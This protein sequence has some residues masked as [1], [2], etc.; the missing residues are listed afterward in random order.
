MLFLYI[1]YGTKIIN[2]NEYIVGFELIH[3]IKYLSKHCITL[4]LRPFK[5]FIK[6]ISNNSLTKDHSQAVYLI[7][8]FN[9]VYFAFII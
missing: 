2:T 4:H 9:S 6:C 5:K 8:G 7:C 1:F 3:Y